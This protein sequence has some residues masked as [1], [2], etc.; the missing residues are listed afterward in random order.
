MAKRRTTETAALRFDVV[1]RPEAI[2]A[3][4]DRV[5]S[6]KGRIRALTTVRRLEGEPPAGRDRA[7]GRR[8][9]RRRTSWPPSKAS[10]T[11]GRST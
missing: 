6:I 5:A 2:T 10:T 11:S 9:S 1:D 3:V 4:A 7:R 8:R